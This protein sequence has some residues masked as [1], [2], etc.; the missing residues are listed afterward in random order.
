MADR[1]NTSL[2]RWGI[3]IDRALYAG[4]P[5][6][7]IAAAQVILQH[8]PQHLP[9]Y[10]RM[11]QAAWAMKAWQDGAIWA[12]RLLRAEPTSP[13]A[14]RALA[15]AAEAAEERSQA[16]AAWQRAFEVAPYDPDIR[17]GISRTSL[18]RPDVLILNQAC[19]AALYVAGRRWAQAATTYASLVEADQRRIDFQASWMTALWQ[20]NKRDDAYKLARYLVEKKEPYLLMGWVVLNTAGD[21]NDQALAQ[22]PI[23]MLDP[24]GEYVRNRFGID[25]QRYALDIPVT[26]AEAEMLDF[27]LDDVE[28]AM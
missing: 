5:Q 4:R 10:H 3:A 19:L 1:V 26:A 21:D 20:R 17:A 13:L 8:L 11:L 15:R 28:E 23:Q 6:V 14:W 18:E 22:Q 12:R 24:E 27:L 2:N 25:Y 16:Q 9:T 7:A